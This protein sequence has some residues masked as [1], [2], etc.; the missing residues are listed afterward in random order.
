M[1]F[2]EHFIYHINFTNYRFWGFRF[3]ICFYADFID[4]L[5][6]IWSN[7][8]ANK[9][10]FISKCTAQQWKVNY[11]IIWCCVSKN[12]NVQKYKKQ[13]VIFTSTILSLKKKKIL[14]YSSC[15][16]KCNKKADPHVIKRSSKSFYW[17]KKFDT[18][19]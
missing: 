17:L 9:I 18:F 14:P 15:A 16:V 11:Y 2:D 10:V 19:C 13:M 12:W 1:L 6:Y 5:I 7:I 8:S 4:M 3:I